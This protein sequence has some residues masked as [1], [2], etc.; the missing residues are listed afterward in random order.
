MSVIIFSFAIVA[1]VFFGLLFVATIVGTILFL[2]GRLGSGVRRVGGSMAL[3]CGLMLSVLLVFGTVA[4]GYQSTTDVRQVSQERRTAVRQRNDEVRSSSGEFQQNSMDRGP[5]P[6]PSLVSKSAAARPTR[7]PD[8]DPYNSSV[9]AMK[10]LSGHDDRTAQ[11]EK[12]MERPDWIRSSKMQD[13]DVIKVVLS[14]KQYATIDEATE[15]LVGAART[16]LAQDFETVFHTTAAGILDLPLLE[17]K[18]LAVREQY[19][20]TIDRDFGNFFAPMH[21]V[22]WQLELSP[23]VRMRLREVWRTRVQE[24]RTGTIVETLLA[25]TAALGVLSLITRKKRVEMH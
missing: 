17:L 13:G 7:F 10:S 12:S 19:V 23:Q 24:T 22:W 14:S 21:R 15:E 1:A 25:M 6:P 5:A 16:L 2:S 18:S 20:E 3:A 4:I 8:V 9:D 11:V